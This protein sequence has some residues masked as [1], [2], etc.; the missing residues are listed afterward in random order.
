MERKTPPLHPSFPPN[1]CR[2]FLHFQKCNVLLF[3][4]EKTADSLCQQKLV[5]TVVFKH[6][7]YHLNGFR[8]AFISSPPATQ[9]ISQ[10]LNVLFSS[11]LPSELRAFSVIIFF[12]AFSSSGFLQ[13]WRHAISIPWETF[14]QWGLA[15]SCLPWIDYKHWTVQ[16]LTVGLIT[17]MSLMLWTHAAWTR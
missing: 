5:H 12:Q 2:I 13:H 9:Y 17:P 4:E 11:F 8:K 16:I 10:I 3:W 1:L 6:S 14:L 7:F 15:D